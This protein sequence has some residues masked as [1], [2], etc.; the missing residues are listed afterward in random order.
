[1]KI[2]WGSGQSTTGGKQAIIDAFNQSQDKIELVNV[3]LSSDATEQHDTYVTSFAAGSNDY[4]IISSN[5]PWPGEFSQAGYALAVDRYLERDGIN[6]DD[7]LPGYVDAYTFQGQM[8]GMPVFGNVALL[9]YR[10]DLIETPPTTWDELIEMAK[11]N[12]GKEGTEYGY[13]IQAA[14]YEG[15]TCNTVDMIAAYGGD[16]IDGDGN[17]VVDCQGTVDALTEMRKFVTE[18]LLP[19]DVTTHQEANSADLFMAGKAV[20]MRNWPAQWMS[21]QDPEKSKVVDKVGYCA[22]PAGSERSAAI[23]GGWG[24]MIYSGTEHPDEA[25]EAVKF[26]SGKEG[27][28]LYATEDLQMPTMISLY[29][30]EEVVAASPVF[31]GLLDAAMTAVKRPV[32]PIYNQISEIMQ[33]EVTGVLVGDTTPEDAAKNMQDK[34]E[35]AVKDNT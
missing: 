32:T 26:I 14:Q 11:E 25:W 19:D 34:M 30:D 13:L 8:W 20:F 16:I 35:Q 12:V 21:I 15:L 6:M 28:K 29:E 7:Y 4:D 18:G 9:Y 10:K 2:V 23:L 31:D 5:V 27:Q 3:E 17:V 22:L 1:M 24:I 33:I